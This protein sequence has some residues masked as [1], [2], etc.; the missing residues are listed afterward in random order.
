MKKKVLLTGIS[1]F[2]G[3]H[4]A[5]ELLK[6]GYKVKGSIRKLSKEQEVRRGIAK[7]VDAKDNLEFCKLDLLN[8]AGW[9]QAMRDCDFVLHVASPFVIAQPKD[10]N[11]LIKPAVD[12]TLRAL[13]FAQKTGV[14]KVVLTSSTVAMAGD[15]KVNHLNEDSW[16]DAKNDKVSAYIKSKTMAE[17]AA[18]DFYSNQTGPNKIQLTVVNPGPI[19]GPTLTGN[20]SGAS[21]EM[22]KKVITGKMPMLPN[23]NYVM[24]DVRDIAKIHVEAL[25]NLKS[26]GRRL[27]VSS[28]KP[29]SFVSVAQIL[30]DG[31]YDKASPKTA[32]SLMVKFMSLFNSE[33]KG[34]L[35]FVDALVS[36]DISPAMEIFKWRPIPFEKTILDTAVSIEEHL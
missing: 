34:M 3:Q 23:S 8:D 36:A 9:E 1:G 14:K 24:S 7:V 5:V 29:H 21:M 22:I 13:K 11:E 30:K 31:G 35:P 12:G 16:T 28:A 25:G 4:C 33:M 19:Y 18:W 17:K 20:L 32:P 2:V 15:K 10:E 6:Q 26:E 27:I